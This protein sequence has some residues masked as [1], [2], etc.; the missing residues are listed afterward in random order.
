MVKTKT[1]TLQIGNSDDK[2]TQAEW[3]DFV[4]SMTNVVTAYQQQI[5]FA[6]GSPSNARWQDFCWVFEME[7]DNLV[8]D[9]LYRQV[10]DCRKKFKQNSAAF[11]EGQTSF[12]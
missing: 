6:S 12:V 2:L 9:A 8:R 7:A 5:H 10:H 3:F 1:I 4:N 11:T